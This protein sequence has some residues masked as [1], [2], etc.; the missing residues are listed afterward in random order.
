LR[1]HGEQ[2]FWVLWNPDTGDIT[3]TRGGHRIDK[4]HPKKGH[5]TFPHNI[6]PLSDDDRNRKPGLPLTGYC[7]VAEYHTHPGGAF[8]PSGQDKGRKRFLKVPLLIITGPD[9][10]PVPY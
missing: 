8:N 10:E 2:G 4:H 3:I 6:S 7:I 1:F 5:V 9:E